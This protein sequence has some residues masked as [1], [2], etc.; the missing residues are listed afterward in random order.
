MGGAALRHNVASAALAPPTLRGHP[1]FHLDVIKS[2]AG[3]GVARDFPVRDS[4]TD[5]NDHGFLSQ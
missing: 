2:Q 5:T 3:F 1:Q 4:A